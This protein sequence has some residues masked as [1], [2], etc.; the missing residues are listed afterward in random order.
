[1]TLLLAWNLVW[2]ILNSY[3]GLSNRGLT[4]PH[5]ASLQ[6][7]YGFHLVG[8][9]MKPQ[10]G[11]KACPSSYNLQKVGLGSEPQS[12]GLQNSG[13]FPSAPECCSE[14]EEKKHSSW[15]Q[16][17]LSSCSPLLVLGPWPALAPGPSLGTTW[18]AG[19]SRS[20]WIS[21]EQGPVD[22]WLCT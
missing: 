18:R 19:I 5:W 16:N 22:I 15:E 4:L 10:R 14:V 1:M 17:F 21:R 3:Y 20:L 6:G 8:E 7:R 13:S 12:A 2:T 11:W 9:K